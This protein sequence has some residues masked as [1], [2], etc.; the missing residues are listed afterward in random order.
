MNGPR[1]DWSKRWISFAE[2]DLA[3]ARILLNAKD[4]PAWATAF[5]AQQCAEKALKAV[6]VLKAEEIPLTHSISMLLDCCEEIG[7]TLTPEL[8]AAGTLTEFGVN[9]KYPGRTTV[10]PDQAAD[11]VKRASLVLEHVRQILHHEG[12]GLT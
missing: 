9:L 10:T 1:R 6:L 11:A 12:L 3:A 7:Y 8:R 4:C 5:H 2:G